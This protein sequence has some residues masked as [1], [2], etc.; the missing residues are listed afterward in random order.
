MLTLHQP[1]WDLVSFSTHISPHFG[2]DEL[3]AL[4]Y[5]SVV[6]SLKRERHNLTYPGA[7]H[8]LALELSHV[9]LVN[10]TS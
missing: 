7:I 2:A 5:A 1:R 6:E 3:D 9:N 10:E 8:T 4:D